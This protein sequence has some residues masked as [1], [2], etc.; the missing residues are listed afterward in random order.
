[1][2]DVMTELEPLGGA[3]R[4]EQGHAQHDGKRHLK[5]RWPG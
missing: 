5:R 2:L 4:A 3:D 1:M